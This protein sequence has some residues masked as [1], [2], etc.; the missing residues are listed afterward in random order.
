[1]AHLCV[2]MKTPR[3]CQKPVAGAVIS[4]VG[5]F[6]EDKIQAHSADL[7]HVPIVETRRSLNGRAVHRWNL[8]A[9][10]DVKAVIALIDLRGH[11]RLEPALEPHGSQ[12]GFSD[13]RERA[14]QSVFFL[15][16]FAVKY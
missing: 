4:S 11:L 8:V 13:D 6:A 1:M 7:N 14:G 3:R 12:G 2:V 15:I 5:L 10:T 16:G 9:R